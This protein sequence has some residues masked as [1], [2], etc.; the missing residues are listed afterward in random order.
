MDLIKSVIEWYKANYPA[1]WLTTDEPYRAQNAIQDAAEML[2]TDQGR[3]V[4]VVIHDKYSGFYLGKPSVRQD[5]VLGKPLIAIQVMMASGKQISEIFGD[6]KYSPPFNP[7]DDVIFVLRD[8]ESEFKNHEYGPRLIQKIRNIIQA[9]ECSDQFFVQIEK[10]EDGQEKTTYPQGKRGSRLLIFTSV[11][12]QIT[13]WV[14]E[15][16]SV[17]VPL[18]GPDVLIDA[19]HNVSESANAAYEATKDL[20]PAKRKGF[21]KLPPET[22]TVLANALQGLTYDASENVIA[23]AVARLRNLNNLDDVLDVIEHEK[24]LAIK[25]IPGVQYYNKEQ[26]AEV[27]LAGYEAA[28]EMIDDYVTLEPELAK[29]HNI[30]PFKGLACISVPGCGKSEF[31]K[32]LARKTGRM[33]LDINL[34]EVQGGIVGASEANM[35]RLVNLTRLLRP[36]ARF[37]DFD[38]GGANVA[39]SGYSGDGGVFARLIQVLLTEMQNKENRSVWAYTINR[40]RNVPGEL[41]RDGR[42][43]FRFFVKRPDPTTRAGI[44]KVHMQKRNFEPLPTQDEQITEV[45]NE[46]DG[47]VGAEI[48]SKIDRTARICLKR[49]DEVLDLD[50]LRQQVADYTPMGKQDQFLKDWETMEKDCEHFTQVGVVKQAAAAAIQNTRG[51]ASRSIM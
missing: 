34:G 1:V 51:R 42:L 50:V 26:L 46:M 41:L 19:V 6:Q 16:K 9:N 44:I 10:D 21:A 25:S 31:M 47:W 35:R 38:K 24:A 23:L 45:A 17:D 12:E 15:L 30:T 8:W 43:D 37:D 4:R 18:P 29:K 48:E 13:Q 39:A 33:M 28:E 22:E 14:P 36:F 7:D 49:G 5:P 3:N 20:K 11:T 40:V 32:L 27:K 2:S